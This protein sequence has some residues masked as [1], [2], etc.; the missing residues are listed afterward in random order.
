MGYSKN[1]INKNNQNSTNDDLGYED[2]LE[3]TSVFAWLRSAALSA[4]RVHTE[5]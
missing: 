5:I 3:A 1:H 4:L 2:N